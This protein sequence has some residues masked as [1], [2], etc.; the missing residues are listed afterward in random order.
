MGPMRYLLGA[1]VLLPTVALAV[2]MLRGR[3]K[4]KSC[5]VADPSVEGHWTVSR[6]SFTS[7]E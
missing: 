1:L 3:V 5:C 6:P 2:G 7:A 4:V